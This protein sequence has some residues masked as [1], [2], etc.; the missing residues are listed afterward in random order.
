MTKS[1]VGKR[2]TT[3]TVGGMFFLIYFFF[4]LHAIEYRFL[5]SQKR[6]LRVD[7]F[8]DLRKLP[9]LPTSEGFLCV[10]VYLYACVCLFFLLNAIYAKLGNCS[11]IAS[12]CRFCCDARV[13][14]LPS[15]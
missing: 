7:F 5:I 6:N 12:G 4:W 2:F 3:L 13:F 1:R 10:F 9:R 8:G 11:K 15:K 14:T